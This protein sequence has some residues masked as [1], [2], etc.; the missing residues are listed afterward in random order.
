MRKPKKDT[1]SHAR[2]SDLGLDR[3]DAL[4]QVSEEWLTAACKAQN[5]K[6]T[7]QDEKDW[8]ALNL[9]CYLV[10]LRSFAAQMAKI[11]EPMHG[12]ALIESVNG[13]LLSGATISQ[14]CTPSA[15]LIARIE[16]G[17]HSKKQSQAGKSSA[18]ARREKW[19]GLATKLAKDGRKERPAYGQEKLA[20]WMIDHDYDDKLPSV[21]ILKPFIGGLE[22]AGVIPQR[23]KGGSKTG[24]LTG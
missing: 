7:T 2:L 18:K 10:S 1:T 19:V 11:S 12:L 24:K 16:A 23:H 8:I 13:L 5:S 3:R 4:F 17:G 21:K 20:S 15:S 6:H 9:D 14:Y 22:K